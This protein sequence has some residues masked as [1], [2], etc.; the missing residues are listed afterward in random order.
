MKTNP[1]LITRAFWHR[2]G[3]RLG[4]ALT[5]L[6]FL[7]GTAKSGAENPWTSSS[8]GWPTGSSHWSSW[9]STTGGTFSNPWISHSESS[10]QSPRRHHAF[11]GPAPA[12]IHDA[13]IDPAM[14]RAGRI[15]EN[16]ALPHSTRRCW[17][18]VKQAL[19]A[20]G[21]V[22]SY[23]QTTYARE[24]GREL[25]HD[26]GFVRL[27]VRS[28]SRAP[29]GSVIVYGGGGAGHV[30]LRTS[31]GYVSDFYHRRPA[32]LPFIGAYSRVDRSSK[33]SP[34]E[35]ASWQSR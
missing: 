24:A 35:A 9:E 14:L 25:V 20:S 11:R 1:S 26:Y 6:M 21:G 28:P 3:V 10:R 31:H 8:M 32:G 4:F 22:E 29:V 15:A 27:P 17:R 16:R 2:D 18:Y 12:P 7:L 34:K 19:V 30:E 13:S 33:E 5:G 23:P